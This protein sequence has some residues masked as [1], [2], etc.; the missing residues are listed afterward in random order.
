MSFEYWQ[1]IERNLGITG[2][3]DANWMKPDAGEP[4]PPAAQA[5]LADRLA[6]ELAWDRTAAGAFLD[7]LALLY[8]TFLE[9][10]D[11]ATLY[12]L[13]SVSFAAQVAERLLREVH[14]MLAELARGAAPSAVRPA[15]VCG[16]PSGGTVAN[17]RRVLPLPGE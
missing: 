13:H 17:D 5:E 14:G 6:D 7:R 3:A 10:I 11:P 2:R 9:A 12:Y 8:E 4:A 16:W 1:R 15:S